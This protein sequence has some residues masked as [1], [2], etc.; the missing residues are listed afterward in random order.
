MPELWAAANAARPR[1][2]AWYDAD[3]KHRLSRRVDNDETALVRLIGDVL[4]LSDGARYHHA[5]GSYWGD[6]K[7]DA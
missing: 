6:G 2:T 3:G 4:E 1:V 7:N 5:A